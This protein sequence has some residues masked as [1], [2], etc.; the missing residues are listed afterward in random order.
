MSQKKGVCQ[1]QAHIMISAAKALGIPARYVSGYMHK[2]Q[3]DS[4]N[5]PDFTYVWGRGGKSCGKPDG[6]KFG[7]D[8]FRD[9]K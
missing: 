5:R 4:K 1:D 2:N 8:W 9:E 7:S 6:G 3:N